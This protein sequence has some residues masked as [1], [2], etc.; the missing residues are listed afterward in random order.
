MPYTCHPYIQNTHACVVSCHG[1][2]D[3]LGFLRTPVKNETCRFV[4][5]VLDVTAPTTCVV[6][7]AVTVVVIVVVT[8]GHCCVYCC[9]PSLLLG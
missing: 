8:F 5:D 7:F 6:A 2:V 4:S 3:S 9:C 1:Y